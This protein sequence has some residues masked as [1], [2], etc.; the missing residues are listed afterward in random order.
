MKKSITIVVLVLA[1]ATM[2]FAHGKP[3]KFM[4]TVK[5]V[6][7]TSLTITT[8]EGQEKTFTLDGKTKFLHSGETAAAS[9]LKVG[10]RV[11]VEADVHGKE[12]KAEVIKFGVPK[13]ESAMQHQ[14]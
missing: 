14:H 3:Q 13:K 6:S 4:G 1:F 9:D 7:A 10:E 8:K 5:S 11:V 12:A 2:A